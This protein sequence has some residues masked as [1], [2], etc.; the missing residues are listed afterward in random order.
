MLGLAFSP[1]GDRLVSTSLDGLAKV[2]DL[3]SGMEISTFRGKI[4]PAWVTNCAFSPDGK[5]VFS[6]VA[7]D[8]AVYQW[9]A[10]TGEGIKEFVDEGKEVYGIAVSLDGRLLASG[11]QDGNIILWDI[12][13]GEKVR[14]ISGHAGLINRLIF[15]QDGTLLS[16]RRI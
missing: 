8:T 12:E 3:T 16:L 15:N 1:D 13:S 7:E 6:N 4:I 9:D 2:W 10:D 5:T 11:N 14:T